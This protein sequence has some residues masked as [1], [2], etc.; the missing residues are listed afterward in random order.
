M[1]FK[2]IIIEVANSNKFKLGLVE[3]CI[4]HFCFFHPVK[5]AMVICLNEIF[6]ITAFRNML[7]QSAVFLITHNYML[8]SEAAVVRAPSLF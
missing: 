7:H 2:I 5:K 4:Y 1:I 3:F 6:F 8:H